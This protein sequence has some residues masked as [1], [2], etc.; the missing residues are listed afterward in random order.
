[1]KYKDKWLN[2][3]P[4]IKKALKEDKYPYCEFSNDGVN[5][6]KSGYVIDYISESDF[7]YE[8]VDSTYFY[9]SIVKEKTNGLKPLWE[10][11]K[12]CMENGYKL[13]DDGDWMH[14]VKIDLTKDAQQYILGNLKEG[15]FILENDWFEDE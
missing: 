2:C 8:T 7:P 3:D 15:K 9:A 6:N 5:Y 11:I 4:D 12:L 10:I 14:P 13:N 1:M